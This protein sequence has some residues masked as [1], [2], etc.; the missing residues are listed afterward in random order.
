MFPLLATLLLVVPAVELALILQ[1]GGAI[2]GWATFALLVVM[3]L[4]GAAL[5]RT[6]GF[7]AARR[8]R[9]ALSTGHEVGASLAEAA[10]ALVAAVLMITPGFLTDLVGMM[11]LLPPVRRR[12]G[13]LVAAWAQRRMIVPIP[14]HSGARPPP[15][16]ID[17]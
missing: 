4:L 12:A 17:V 9:E 8:V 11:L 3:A 15:G 6:M 14:G 16:V 10:V 5:A 1:V 7:A 2:G 13:R